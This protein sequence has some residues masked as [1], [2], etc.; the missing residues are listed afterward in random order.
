MGNVQARDS[1]L[2]DYP[3]IR[4]QAD[5]NAFVDDH[6]FTSMETFMDI[7]LNGEH[8][9]TSYCSPGDHED[10]VAQ[11]SATLRILSRLTCRRTG[12]EPMS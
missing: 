11:K 8:L 12:Q 6:K 1:E 5:Q 3:L 10:L 7:F 9:C 2:I 4:Y